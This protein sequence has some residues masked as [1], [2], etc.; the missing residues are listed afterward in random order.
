MNQFK[1]YEACEI[2]SSK[3]VKIKSELLGEITQILS[4]NKHKQE[5]IKF[6]LSELEQIF[7]YSHPMCVI[8]KN[9]NIIR[10]NE[11]FAKLF[12]ISL[13]EIIG[14]KCYNIWQGPLCNTSECLMKKVLEGETSSD[15]EYNRE[16]FEGKIIYCIISAYPYKNLD[17]ETIG[18][19]E[20][21]TDITERK[22]ST[23]NLQESEQK[24]RLITE[25]VNDIILILNQNLE[26]EVINEQ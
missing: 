12:Q 8:D 5:E 2:Q 17:G 4:E 26:V 7:K 11:T 19:I 18:V 24:Y 25:N 16:N 10:T 14:E 3:T 21:I 15:Y 9:F 6:S 23:K 13:D 1:K 20:T 22:E